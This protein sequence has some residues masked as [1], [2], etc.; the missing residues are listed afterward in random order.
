MSEAQLETALHWE[1]VIGDVNS[2]GVVRL[3]GS[4]YDDFKWSRNRRTWSLYPLSLVDYVQEGLLGV[5]EKKYVPLSVNDVIGGFKAS[6]FYR[7]RKDELNDDF[8]A[9]CLQVHPGILIDEDS[10]C[11]LEKWERRR[12]DEIVLA[13]REVSEPAHYSDIAEKTNEL[14]DPEMRT[15]AHNIH[16]ILGRRT[17]LF[18]RVGHGIYGLTAWGLPDDGSVANAAYR[19][20]REAGKPLHIDTITDGVLETWQVR[21]I[22]VYMAVKND[23]RFL[24]IGPGMYALRDRLSGQAEHETAADFGDLFGERL[25][26]WQAELDKQ[27]S[28]ADLDT[29]AEVDTIRDIGLDFFSG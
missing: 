29:H 18:V 8:I 7:S 17:D 6:H 24:H 3:I 13:L 23:P 21:R 16:A 10:L 4:L 12:T 5:L 20:L 9:A 15:S 25:A 22:S 11:S 2:L 26:R 1:L 19:V 27:Q 14:L 28:S